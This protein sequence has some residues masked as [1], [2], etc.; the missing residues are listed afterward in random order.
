MVV[1]LGVLS[2]PTY[3]TGTN[4]NVNLHDNLPGNLTITPPTTDTTA[5]GGTVIISGTVH[6]ISQ[7]MLYIDGVYSST[8]P[9]D[10]GAS[11]YSFTITLDPGDHVIKLV[12]VD[13]YYGTQVMQSIN[14][15]YAPTGSGPQP[16]TQSPSGGGVTVGSLALQSQ[17]NQASGS[18]PL[19]TLADGAY[20]FFVATDLVS[21]TDGQGANAMLGRFTLISVG[22]IL[23]AF[24]WMSYWFVLR[25][26]PLVPQY[27]LA[28]GRLTTR[29]RL[30][31]VALIVAPLVL[32]P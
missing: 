1:S 21:K 4:V 32:L 24:P 14:V 25:R 12:G 16:V 10:V 7:I 28:T 17:V 13:P 26:I 15:S 20:N 2:A 27:S 23:A 29:V 5:T 6:N 11:D 8:L 9:L 31:G 3:A 30:F 18:G 19:K 22:A